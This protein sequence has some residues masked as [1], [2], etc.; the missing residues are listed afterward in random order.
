MRIVLILM[1]KTSIDYVDDGVK[2]YLGRLSKYVKMEIEVLA[3]VRNSSSLSANELRAK[4]GEMILKA[5][6]RNSF[7]VLLDEKGRTID[8]RGFAEF[9]Q[10]MMNRSTQR[11]G[12][13]VGG[14]WGF[15]DR[16]RDKANDIISLSKMTFS[17]QLV[18]LLFMEQLYRAFTIL[19]NEPYHND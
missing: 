18:R 4:E 1:G 7:N 3:P 19:R 2:D 5:M 10:Q 9:L 6:S 13:V 16:V 17:H 8:S 15:D 11:L 12:F 14:A